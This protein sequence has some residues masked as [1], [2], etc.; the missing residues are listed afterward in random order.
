MSSEAIISMRRKKRKRLYLVV[1][2]IDHDL[3]F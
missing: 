2:D 1:D 3:K